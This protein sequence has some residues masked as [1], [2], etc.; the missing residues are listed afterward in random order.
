MATVTQGGTGDFSSVS[1]IG[2][3]NM[4]TVTQN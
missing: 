2:N 3:G 4:I 1:Q